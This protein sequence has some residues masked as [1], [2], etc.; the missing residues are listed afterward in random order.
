MAT[1]GAV[2][3]VLVLLFPDVEVLD[4]TGP[5][6]VFATTED[7]RGNPLFRVRTVA[8]TADPVAAIGG[9]RFVPD[10]T[11]EDAPDP[12]LLVIPGGNGRRVQMHNRATIAWIRAKAARA[13]QVLSICSG[14]FLLAAAG[15]LDGLEATTHHSVLEEFH[16]FADKTRVRRSRFIDNGRIITSAGISAGIDA[17][18]HLVAR[19]HGRETALRTAGMMEY[20]SPAWSAN[21]RQI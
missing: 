1:V 19:L 11:F 8:E 7:A 2:R 12:H 10:H 18:L 17:S 21:L 16:Q 6:E 3:D 4:A 14:A 15:L 5:F 13:E 9:L 20:E